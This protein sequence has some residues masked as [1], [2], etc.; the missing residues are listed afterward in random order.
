M[1]WKQFLPIFLFLS[2]AL[3]LS[4][5]NNQPVAVERYAKIRIFLEKP[6]DALELAQLGLALDHVDTESPTAVVGEFSQTDLNLLKGKFR[7]EVLVEDLAA[8]YAERIRV[9]QLQHNGKPVEDRAFPCT[10][11]TP[12]Y[13]NTGSFGG[14]LTL[15]EVYAELDEMRA[16]YPNLITARQPLSG[17]THEGRS[18]YWVR[19]SDNADTDESEPEALYT[20][21]HHAREPM[22]I[23]NLIFF[24][25]YILEYYGSDPEIQTLINE[26]E[27]Y[28]VPVLNPDGYEYNR[29]TNPGGGGMWRKNRRNNGN[30]TYGVDLNRN[31]GFQWGYNN[32][33]SSPTTS[34]DTYR[35]PGAFS[36][37]E[38]QMI[39][40]FCLAH[41]FVTALN[42][43]AYGNYIVLPWGYINSVPESSLF[44]SIGDDLNTCNNYLVGNPYATVGYSTNGSS[45]DWMYGEQ[46]TKPKIYAMTPEIGTSA[47]GF[48]PPSS[49]ILPYCEAMM[50]TNLQMAYYTRSL[51]CAASNLSA[52]PGSNS[53]LVSWTAGAG[54]TGFNVR[55][56]VSGTATWTTVNTTGNALTILGLNACT[57]YEV[58]VQSLCAD[59]SGQF[60]ASVNFT[61]TS[62][63]LPAPW[64]SGNIG[65]TG[66]FGSECYTSASGNY[67][68][69]GAGN[70][71]NTSVDGFRFIYATLNGNGSITA[72]INSLT[73][74]NNHKAGVMIRESLANNARHASSLIARA[75]GAWR[76]QW[77]YRT[78]AGGNAALTQPTTTTTPPYWVRITRSGNTFTAFRS[79]NG[80][81][82]N[83]T[84]STTIAM[85][86]TTYIGLAVASG[87]TT[88]SATAA[89]NSVSTTGTLS[90]AGV[91]DRSGMPIPASAG[92]DRPELEAAPNPGTSHINLKVKL[93]QPA[94]VQIQLLDLLGKV[95]L[96]LPAQYTYS[97]E[98]FQVL[99]V[100]ENLPAGM[101]VVRCSAGGAPAV[102]RWMKQ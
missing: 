35:G 49:K 99:E 7:Y 94:P 50:Y 9:D 54:A 52:T 82:W 6:A 32:T 47:D 95:V 62:D 86:T 8:F 5:Q 90:L 101:Y 102:L 25:H 75:S 13:F 74:T 70:L 79:S 48:W 43:H 15:N 98:S 97:T 33:G 53:A 24:M 20:G 58:Q 22:S 100:P 30:G 89:I 65:S 27:L 88:G 91:D 2:C 68:V 63:A 44:S 19:I 46:S 55:Y 92:A 78:T 72:K 51:S 4:A 28:F 17:A 71:A 40:D 93:T 41:Q 57:A 69:T 12:T 66:G 37:P 34:S 73:T 36:E 26:T 14:Y 60:S 45:D 96:E 67:A 64:L 39:R 11:A 18:L 3:G 56:R 21:L 87:V 16:L 42:D 59:L 31:Y 61:T 23:M 1:Y 85:G 76:T 38:T 80:T 81:T 77:L 83:Q 29:S 10:Y 84:G